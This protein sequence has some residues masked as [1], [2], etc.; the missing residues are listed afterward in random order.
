MDKGNFKQAILETDRLLLKELNPDIIYN[1]F[2]FYTDQEIV[3]FLGLRSENE[4][5]LERRKF[6]E[7]YTTFNTS[8]KHF[9]MVDKKT[10]T[11]IGKTGFRV[12]HVHHY[13]AE[14]G[15]SITDERYL[16]KGYMTEAN[17]AII[18]FGFEQMGLNRIEAFAGPNNIASLKILRSLG[19]TEEGKLR[20]HYFKDNRMEDSVCFGLLKRE[21]DVS[22]KGAKTQN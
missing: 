22:R 17:R 10:G 3:A 16:N 5:E 18:K 12:W 13:R 20:E 8:F 11:V 19:F 2:N 1:L 4:L 6:D 7:G 14:I 9:L 15:Y 21:Y